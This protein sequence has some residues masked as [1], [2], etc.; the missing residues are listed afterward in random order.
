MKPW[1]KS[2]WKSCASFIKTYRYLGSPSHTLMAVRMGIINGAHLSTRTAEAVVLASA[3]QKSVPIGLA[4]SF[5][6][7]TSLWIVVLS[8]PLDSTFQD[9]PASIC[10]ADCPWSCRACPEAKW[11]HFTP[12][13]TRP[14]QGNIRQQDLAP[15]SHQVTA[16][17]APTAAHGKDGVNLGLCLFSWEGMG[18]DVEVFCHCSLKMASSSGYWNWWQKVHFPQ[19]EERLHVSNRISLYVCQ[20]FD[21]F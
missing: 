2:P 8:G 18:G 16:C 9:F 19:V 7:Y 20:S 21:C 4:R 1:L 10:H 15:Q 11:A 6:R 14:G 12:T 13:P 17:W 3:D 5:C